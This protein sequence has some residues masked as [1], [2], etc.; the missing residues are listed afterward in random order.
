MNTVQLKKEINEKLNLLNTKELEEAYG[1]LLVKTRL[2][3]QL[4]SRN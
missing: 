3:F 4:S 2:F 1:V